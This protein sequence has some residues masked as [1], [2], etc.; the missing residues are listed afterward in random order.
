MQNRW[1]VDE[2]RFRHAFLNVLVDVAY[3]TQP[4]NHILSVCD[5]RCFK[6][7]RLKKRLNLVLWALKLD[8][9]WKQTP[10]SSLK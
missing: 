2:G 3:I 1:L 7:Y 5:Y 10:V 9:K 4:V 8:E 6:C